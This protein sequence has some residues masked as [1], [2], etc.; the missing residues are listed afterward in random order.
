MKMK[1]KSIY[2]YS[3]L[4]QKQIS[5]QLALRNT[6]GML[7]EME[8]KVKTKQLSVIMMLK[9]IYRRVGGLHEHEHKSQKVNITQN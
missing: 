3:T 1:L 4:F 5:E 6:K 9:A 8:I 2:K 7:L